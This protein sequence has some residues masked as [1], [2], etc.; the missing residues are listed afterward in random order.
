MNNLKEAGSEC[1]NEESSASDR[2]SFERFDISKL[3]KHGASLLG[4][5]GVEFEVQDD[6]T[7]KANGASGSAEHLL[8]A[9]E[10]R[11]E[12][13]VRAENEQG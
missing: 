2:L 5:A 11:G 3:L 8:E 9:G 6:K 7:V 1:S 13:F 4:S 10:D 12:S